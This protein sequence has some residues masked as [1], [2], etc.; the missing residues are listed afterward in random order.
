LTEQIDH[1]FETERRNAL[2]EVGRFGGRDRTSREEEEKKIVLSDG[3][4][5]S[6]GKNLPTVFN[7]VRKGDIHRQ[8]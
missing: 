4:P 7:K 2:K 3:V 6:G 1:E 8:G 5:C